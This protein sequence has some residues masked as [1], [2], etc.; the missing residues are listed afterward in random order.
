[1]M[2]A[3]RTFNARARDWRSPLP[4]LVVFFPRFRRRKRNVASWKKL[5][6]EMPEA[7]N[8]FPASSLSLAAREI[9]LAA[10]DF[11]AARAKP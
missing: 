3:R 4:P 2:L 7:V 6:E 8:S 9:K 10:S 1:M 11:G 5:T